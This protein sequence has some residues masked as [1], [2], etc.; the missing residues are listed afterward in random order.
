[1]KTYQITDTKKVC[2]EDSFGTTGNSI[3]VMDGASPL[4]KTNLTDEIN[5][6]VWIVKWW[7]RY[8]NE[9][10]S[11]LEKDIFEILEC[12][13]EKLNSEFSVFA[14]IDGL[15]KL[16]RASAGIAIARI[17]G[18]KLECFVLGDVEIN[19]RKKSGGIE[20]L[21][22]KSVEVLD[23]SVI[24]LMLKNEKRESELEFS[25]FTNEELQLLR[26]NRMKM[27]T[28]EGYY[29][30]EHNTK[31]VCNGIYREYRIHEIKD[32]L[33]MTDGYSAIYNKYRHFD[34]ETLMDE[35]R[36]KGLG[37]VLSTLRKIEK[38]DCGM[39]KHGRLKRHDDAT[40][41]LMLMED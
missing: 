26:M 27:N 40:A 11:N 3:W 14:D 25:G 22:D 41:V 30:L 15:S 39:K 17:N 20:L 29:I 31:A 35:C 32:I 34:I 6:V 7:T 36:E 37:N 18:E 19:I 9:N 4:N 8:L 38:E 24:E 21:T 28:K 5:D 10:I 33:M 1:M 12:G 2:N 23:N 16:D 13:I